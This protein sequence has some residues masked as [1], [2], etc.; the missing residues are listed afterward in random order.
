MRFSDLRP[1]TVIS[2]ATGLILNTP[3]NASFPQKAIYSVTIFSS[4]TFIL[5][6]GILLFG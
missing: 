1:A 6:Y 5:L 3:E 2:Y 4:S